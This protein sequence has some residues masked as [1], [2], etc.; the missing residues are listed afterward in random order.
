MGLESLQ[1]NF[2]TGRIEDLVKWARR[3]SVWPATFGLACC[4]IEMMATGRRALR[5]VAL[6]HGDLPRQPPPGRPHDRGRPGEPEDGAGAAPGLRPDGRAEVGHLDGRLREQRR[7]VQQLRHRPGRRPDRARRRLR[8]RLPA[9]ARDA[10]ARH[11][12][13]LRPDP[14]RRDHEAPRADAPTVAPAI[15]IEARDGVPSPAEARRADDRPM[16][17]DAAPREENHE[18]AEGD[19]PCAGPIPTRWRPRSSSASPAR[20][21]STPTAS[22]WS[23][24]HAE[25]WHDVAALLRDEEQFTQCLDVCAVDHLV[26]AARVRAAGR[27]TPSASRW[28]RTSSRTPATAASV[29]IAQVPVEATRGRQHRRP[30]SG[31]RLRRARDLRP[32]RHRVRRSP[33]PHAHP[34]ARR[35]GR[36]PAAQGRRAEPRCRSPSRRTRGRGTRR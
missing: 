26:D 4:A 21:S 14:E 33:R 18:V 6:G 30:L 12:H 17:D 9:R 20:C 36:P 13:A 32:L 24:S 10:H 31:H 7:D 2:L 15:Q 28:W 3:S 23:T 35:L 5:P 27:A 19:A 22:R 16:P 11:P 1:H 8:A 34:D 25:H 29:L